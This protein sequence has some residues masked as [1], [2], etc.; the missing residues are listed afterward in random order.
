MA[1]NVSAD[2]RELGIG[3]DIPEMTDEAAEKYGLD[4]NDPDTKALIE[5]FEAER[6]DPKKLLAEHEAKISAESGNGDADTGVPSSDLP[7]PNGDTQQLAPPD[8]GTKVPAPES[9]APDTSHTQESEA[10]GSR[11]SSY[12]VD[13]GDGNTVTLDQQQAKSLVQLGQWA[14][15]L[16][17]DTRN[18]FAAIEQGRAAVISREDYQA[19]QAW[20]ANG[21]KAPAATSSAPVNLE[22]LTDGERALYEE[23]QALRAQQQQ[24]FDQ[25]VRSRAE[26]ENARLQQVIAQR[27]EVFAKTFT[28]TGAA[29][30]LTPEEVN[31]ALKHAGESRLV[32][33]VNQ[34]L[35]TRLPDG[36]VIDGDPADIARVTLERA[37]HQIPSLRQKVID[38]EVEARLEKE[39]ADIMKVNQKKSRAGSL[40]AAPSAATT[41]GRDPRTMTPQER[42]AAIANEIRLAIQQDG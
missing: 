18:A 10:T 19:F 17:D 20:K 8:P 13:F 9:T 34:E 11:Q 38:A 37:V 26:S 28:E 5:S 16:N 42:D 1:V 31:A 25:D 4:L 36:R 35:S 6:P 7:P 15:A 32:A 3:V 40:A 12:V 22:D 14:Q 27:G 41:V 2:L 33:S 29:M 23:V 39:R 30:N 24:A 21:A